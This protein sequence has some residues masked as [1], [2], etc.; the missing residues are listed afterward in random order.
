ME[1]I[2]QLIAASRWEDLE[3]RLTDLAFLE[4]EAETGRAFELA[5]D[6]STA[7]EALPRAR[8]VR[9]LLVLLE[10]ALR[11]SVHFIAGHPETLFQCLWN[12][13]WW[14]DCDEA[15]AHYE[16][17]SSGTPPW[18]EPLRLSALLRH[19]R[20]EKEQRSPG[21]F[22]VRSLFPPTGPLGSAQRIVVPLDPCAWF[23][24][25]LSFSYGDR[26][27][28]AWMHPPGRPEERVFRAWETSLGRPLE[29]SA[30]EEQVGD[31][32]LSPDGRWRLEVDVSG[33]GFGKP[34]LLRDASSGKEV[35]TIPG[36]PNTS[37]QYVA[38]SADASRAA[39]AGWGGAGIGELA[40][41]KLPTGHRLF[42]TRLDE[43]VFALAMSPD[44]NRVACGSAEGAIQLFDVTEGRL[45]GELR[46][47]EGTIHGL[48]F[49]PNGQFLASASADRTIRLW[50]LS[51]PV[52]PPRRKGHPDPICA[53]LFSPDG[54]WLVT[55]S[56]NETTWLWDA[57]TGS[58]VRCL[59]S[60]TEF[61]CVGHQAENCLHI[62][63]QRVL[64]LGVE[65][66]EWPFE[67]ET[68]EPGQ[69]AEDSSRGFPDRRIA[70]APDGSRCA[71]CS[72][73]D[74]ELIILDTVLPAAG[75]H[76][77]GHNQGVREIAFSHDGR[78]LLSASGDATV[79]VWE[80]ATGQ[81]LTCLRGHEA[82]VTSAAFSAD[83]R[84]LVSASIDGTVRVWDSR[85]GAELARLVIPDP[86]ILSEAWSLHPTLA[87]RRVGFCDEDRHLATLSDSDRI[88]VWDVQS[89][90]CLAEHRGVTDFAA[91]IAGRPWRVFLRGTEA[92]IEETAT[93]RVVARIPWSLG[94]RTRAPLPDPSGRTWVGSVG[95]HLLLFTLCGGSAR[96]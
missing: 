8:P 11:R 41:W 57:G 76:L 15:A 27:L 75:V 65:R 43:S 50:D 92:E 91:F 60:S 16:P 24:E 48:A 89:G 18:Q 72:P 88:R 64:S 66:R 80:V 67:P 9:R 53:C 23:V 25:K 14:Y 47:H 85:T 38:F 71:V 2:Q 5:E 28:R 1:S 61:V 52:A 45:G 82:G 42:H 40:V 94:V 21:F 33:G 62:N 86:G 29:V 3:R 73:F 56:T 22:W 87:V 69:G 68:G 30:P 54:K 83:A 81:C 10:E 58:P 4:A 96:E 49:S 79:R 17:A 35:L 59:H 37:L 44:G 26:R 13:A 34:L 90:A 70:W 36:L 74:G 84:R 12:L 6:F 78:L 93:S 20:R 77:E 51:R 95:R 32:F 55:L 7:V 31:P 63:G 39:A 46:G 19:W